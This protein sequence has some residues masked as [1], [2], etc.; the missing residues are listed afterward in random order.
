MFYKEKMNADMLIKFMKRLIKSADKK[1]LLIL[2][3]LRV[4]HSK[5]VK[6]WLKERTNAI[7]IFYLPSYGPDLNPDEYLNNGLK[8]GVSLRPDTR[9]KGCLEKNAYSTYG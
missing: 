3:N 2:D 6:E 7:E 4:Y 9:Q 1:V 5:V 8:C